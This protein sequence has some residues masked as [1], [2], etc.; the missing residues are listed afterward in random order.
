MSREGALLKNTAIITVGK[1]S[2]QMISFLLLPLYTA[3]LSTEEFGIVDLLNT[4]VSLMLPIVTFQ[5]EQAVFRHLIDI[6]GN[7]EQSKNI[8]STTLF[9]ITIQCIVYLMIFFAISGFIQNEYKFFL[10]TNVVACIFSSIM[11]QIARGLGDNKTY[12]VGSFI[13]ALSTIIFNVIFLVVFKYGA[14]GML[15]ASLLANIL[16]AIYVFIKDKI[17]LYLGKYFS[18]I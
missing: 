16:C 6:R 1:V 17:I 2:T 12:A 11:L 18:G 3:I 15:I 14:Y 8:I 7:K 9:T 10:A 4:L 5:I 13:T